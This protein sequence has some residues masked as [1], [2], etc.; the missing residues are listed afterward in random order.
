MT[1]AVLQ[2][3]ALM[4]TIEELIAY[5]IAK[6]KECKAQADFGWDCFTHKRLSFLEQER[7]AFYAKQHNQIAELLRELVERR[8]TDSCEGCKHISLWENEYENGLSCP[9]LRCARRAKDNYEP[10]RRTE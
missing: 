4:L 6:A 10:E 5:E 1:F 8:K 7:N 9:C 3:G 2:K